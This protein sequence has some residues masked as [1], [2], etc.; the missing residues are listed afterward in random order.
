MSVE[1]YGR[2]TSAIARTDVAQE[3]GVSSLLLNGGILTNHGIEVTLNF[4]PYKK[5]D[6][7]WT[8]GL[9]SARNW[10][11]SKLSDLTAKADGVNHSDFLSGNSSRPL[12]KGKPL[13]AFWS[14]SFAGLDPE[15]GYPLFNYIDNNA[16]EA[17]GSQDVDPLSFLVYSGSSEPVFDGG[18]N[19]RLRWKGLSFGANFAIALG[20]KKRLP[21]PYSSFTQ[22]KIP[23]PFSNISKTLNKRWKKKGDETFTHIPAIY[24]SVE[25]I[26]NLYLPNGL[27]MSRYDMWAQSDVMVVDASYLRCTQLSLAYNFPHNLCSKIGLSSISVNANINNLFVIA[28]KKWNGYDPELGDSITPKIYSLGLSVGF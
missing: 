28:S 19:T 13:A 25:D 4:T 8:V 18:L 6:F 24:T 1:Y 9:T 3:Y 15:N 17:Y 20:A 26:Y 14:F 2:R 10:N 11:R 5:D 7:A 12:K 21:N 22:G 23:S 27:Y 16:S